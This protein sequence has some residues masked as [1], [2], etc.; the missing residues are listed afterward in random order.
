MDGL[1]LLSSE[2][3]S[4]KDDEENDTSPETS[5]LHLTP[6]HQSYRTPTGTQLKQTLRNVVTTLSRKRAACPPASPMIANKSRECHLDFPNTN[7][8]IVGGYWLTVR[9]RGII[10]CTPTPN[11]HVDNVISLL[12]PCTAHHS[13][14]IGAMDTEFF[15]LRTTLMQLTERVQYLED[16]TD[17]MEMRTLRV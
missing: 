11:T 2:Y 7:L 17:L 3:E 1:E 4:N 14:R 15:L 10:H 5:P 16:E 13:H 8:S 12:V 6:S 9:G